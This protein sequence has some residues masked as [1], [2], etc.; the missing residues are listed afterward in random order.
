M[1]CDKVEEY[2][3]GLLGMRERFASAGA[4]FK[5]IQRR[6]GYKIDS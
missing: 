4:D 2:G 1:S 3:I 6:K 5:C